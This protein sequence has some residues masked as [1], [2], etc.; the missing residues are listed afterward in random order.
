MIEYILAFVSGILVKAVD[1]L[2]D[3]AKSR[4]PVKYALAISYG[5]FIGLIIGTASFAIIFLSALMA[6]V[7]AR[8]IDTAAHRLGFVV[9]IVS[10]LYF[11]FSSIDVPLFS[12]FL[13]LAFLDEVD[14]VGPLR[15]LTD[16]RPF[17][18][19]GALAMVMFGRLDYFFGIILFDAGYVL[20]ELLAARVAKKK[21]KRQDPTV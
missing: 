19:V 2:E 14:Y 17:L 20:V 1:W 8:K 4:H 13:L 3:D 11:G 15:P 18:K 5:L 9:S 12:F 21:V 6:Q 7:F 16:Y 10:L